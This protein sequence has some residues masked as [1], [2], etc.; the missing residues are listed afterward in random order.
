MIKNLAK[1]AISSGG[2]ITPLIIPSS[3]TGGLGLTNPSI[4][5]DTN[6]DLL[7]CLR[8]VNYAFYL[9]ENNQEFKT[10]WGPLSY[11]NPEDDVNLRTQNYIC[12]LNPETYQIDEWNKVDTSKLDVK[13]IWSFIGLEDARIVRWDES[14]YLTGVRRDTTTNG[15]GRMELSEIVDNKEISRSRIEPPGESTY[16]EKNWMP[17]MDQPFHYVK[18]TVPTEIVKVDP[19]TKSS[20]VVKTVAN[21]HVKK[22]RDIRGSSPI[23]RYKDFYVAITHEVDL[24]FNQKEQKDS[25]YFN[26]FVVW[27]LDWNIKHISAEFWMMGGSIDFTNGLMYKDGHFIIPFGQHDNAAYIIKLPAK[28]FEYLVGMSTEKPEYNILDEGPLIDFIKDPHDGTAAFNLAELYYNEGHLASAMVYYLKSAEWN[29]SEYQKY[30]SAYMVAMCIA[31][32]G[33]RDQT[34]ESLWFNLINFWPERP[35]GYLALSRYYEWR[36]NPVLGYSYAKMAFDRRASETTITPNSTI[37]PGL[38][39]KFQYYK[40]LWEVGKFDE[41]NEALRNMYK[42]EANSLYKQF[43]KEALVKNKNIKSIDEPI[44]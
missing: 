10:K 19:E 24:W 1:I 21:D 27:D 3:E 40:L 28:S 36:N 42:T 29:S 14:L 43:I 26:R 12:K 34:E 4:M 33:R 38:S 39:I 44:N 25:K 20:R 7:L 17:I 5:E 16:C 35:E 41:S 2:S 31:K 22:P 32:L 6:G 9:S 8:H 37:T 15:Q 23:V 18:W 30:E 13:P 11:L